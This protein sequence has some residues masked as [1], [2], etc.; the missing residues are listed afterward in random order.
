M[1]SSFFVPVIGLIEHWC[2]MKLKWLSCVL[3]GWRHITGKLLCL[4]ESL[5]LWFVFFNIEN[6]VKY[7]LNSGCS[8]NQ[9]HL[10]SLSNVMESVRR[11]LM[12]FDYYFS[13]YSQWQ[14]ILIQIVWN[15]FKIVWYWKCF[16]NRN[17]KKIKKKIEHFNYIIKLSYCCCIG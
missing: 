7:V 9:N 11:I 12:G 13:P 4:H 17:A 10:A 2:T 15:N 3:L 6:F 1:F 14:W 5:F 16:D 8:Q